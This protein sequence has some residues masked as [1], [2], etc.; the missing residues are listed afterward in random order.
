MDGIAQSRS[1]GAVCSIAM[2]GSR[3]TSGFHLPRRPS[4]QPLSYRLPSRLWLRI[5]LSGSD[6]RGGSDF[7][8]LPLPTKSDH[9]PDSLC[10][11]LPRSWGAHPK[12]VQSRAG[13]SPRA[14][15][16]R[17]LQRP[18]PGR[19]CSA[20]GAQTR[21]A[22]RRAP[23]C[24]GQGAGEVAATPFRLPTSFRPL[25]PM[26]DRT[27]GTEGASASRVVRWLLARPVGGQ[28][29]PPSFGSPTSS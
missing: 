2:L 25:P 22:T 20:A 13:S 10:S 4:S 28:G 1:F 29:Q 9:P 17:C 11:A 19:R 6:I 23:S 18:A 7:D 12:S 27:W 21:A 24:S 5:I 14:G 3:F 16:F 8:S 26:D 15:V